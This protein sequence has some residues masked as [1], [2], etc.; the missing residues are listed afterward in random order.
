M[1]IHKPTPQQRIKSEV[2]APTTMAATAQS[3]QQPSSNNHN[4]SVTNESLEASLLNGG[5]QQN[6]LPRVYFQRWVQLIYLSLLALLSDWVCFSLAAAPE[7]FE[8][9]YEGYSSASLIDLF[10]FVNVASCFCVTDLVAKFGMKASIRTSAG[11]MC[12]GCWFRSGL[13]LWDVELESIESVVIGT[14]LVAVAQPFF[15]C[16]PPLLSAQWFASSE[17]ATSTAV[18]LN[19]NQVGIATAFLVGGVMA[20]S[21]LGL[22]NYFG[23]MSICSTVLFLGTVLQYQEEP[24][25][26][27][28]T[29][30]WKKRTSNRRE[31]PF[32]LSVVKF[33]K[34]PGFSRP[35]AAFICSIAITN[36]VGV[37]LL[38]RL[39]ATTNQ[40]KLFFVV[41]VP[42]FGS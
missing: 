25:I 20:T 17:R 33:F 34:T 27:P 8:K 23:L 26:A 42:S 7:A 3:S 15:Q 31:P 21:T 22:S 4:I 28:S 5:Q 32:R 24:E 29:S 11:L 38:F 36:I 30:E 9:Y 39:W 10:L 35:L 18:A 16:T 2:Q 14:I 12:V 1:T 13:N 37:S 41:V 19:F 40:P 6:T